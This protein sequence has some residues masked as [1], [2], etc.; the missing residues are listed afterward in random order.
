MKKTP[1]PLGQADTPNTAPDFDVEDFKDLYWPD[2]GT[3]PGE[4]RCA[5]GLRCAFTSAGYKVRKVEEAETHP[6]LIIRAVRNDA[7]R[8]TDQ[9]LFYR[10]VRDILRDAGFRLRR[11]ELTVARTGNR[12][13]LAFRWPNSS[14]DYAAGL[15]RAEQEAAEFADMPL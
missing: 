8:I 1:P 9:R 7:R 10:H 14:I 6:V 11:G 2:V 15:R 5:F 3:L 13:L 12:I 4:P